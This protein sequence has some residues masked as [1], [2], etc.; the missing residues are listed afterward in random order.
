[1]PFSDTERIPILNI[2]MKATDDSKVCSVE[3]V[4]VH[5]ILTFTVILHKQFPTIN[6]ITTLLFF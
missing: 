6:Y 4:I 3:K 5:F 2:L 1:M